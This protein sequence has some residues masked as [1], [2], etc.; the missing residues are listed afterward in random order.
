MGGIKLIFALIFS[1]LLGSNDYETRKNAEAALDYINKQVDLRTA[2]CYNAIQTADIQVEL[3]IYKAIEAYYYLEFDFEKIDI[4]KFDFEQEY[5][6]AFF[7]EL[8]KEINKNAYMGG[9][10][11][12]YLKTGMRNAV[13]Y[14]V[15][16]MKNLLQ[17]LKD[18]G[19]SRQT[20]EEIFK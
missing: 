12:E 15:E 18:V 17:Y 13:Y 9:T 11:L 3:S 6:A 16:V 7:E 4:D 14:K 5:V 1:S 10:N 20:I 8:L 2:L 19:V